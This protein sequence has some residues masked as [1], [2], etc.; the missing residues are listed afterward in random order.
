MTGVPPVAT[1]TVVEPITGSVVTVKPDVDDWTV[2]DAV[3]RYP[4][5]AI[6]A[7]PRIGLKIVLVQI[8]VPGVAVVTAVEVCAAFGGYAPRLEYEP[9]FAVGSPDSASLPLI[10]FHW[11][12]PRCASHSISS[13]R[14]ARSLV[15]IGCVS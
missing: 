9:T 6:V 12:R 3:T 11:C 13:L 1:F 8:A 15:V 4:L 14:N 2:P 7:L 10:S 5:G